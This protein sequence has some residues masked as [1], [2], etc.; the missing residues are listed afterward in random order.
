MRMACFVALALAAAPA[1]AENGVSNEIEQHQL[2]QLLTIR[3]VY[4]D[5]LTGGE[6]ASQMR[7]MLIS[8]LQNVRLF[9]ITEN[10]DRADATLRGSG[11]DLV[12]TESHATGEGVSA[13]A[14]LGIARGTSRT[15]GDSAGVGLSEN[16]STHSTERRHEAVAAIRLVG[17]DGDVIWSTTQESTGAKFHGASADV[18]DKVVRSLKDDFERARRSGKPQ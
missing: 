16:E 9:V 1:P 18:A 4:V 15:R 10:Q 2:Q 17:K 12:Y 13:R 3:R 7:D 11:E 14:N 8:S 5:R 6:T